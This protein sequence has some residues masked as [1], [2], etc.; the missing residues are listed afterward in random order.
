LLFIIDSVELG[1][2]Q[3]G[4]VHLQMKLETYLKTGA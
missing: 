3:G 4:T 2:A 1:G